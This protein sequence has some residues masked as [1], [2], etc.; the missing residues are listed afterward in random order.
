MRILG[1]YIERVI[2]FDQEINRVLEN[3]LDYICDHLEITRDDVRQ[4]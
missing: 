1:A 3:N 2:K 4:A